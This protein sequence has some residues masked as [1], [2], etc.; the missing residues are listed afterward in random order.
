LNALEYYRNKGVE[1]Y[2]ESF[3]LGDDKDVRFVSVSF[4]LSLN[5]DV[6]IL[7]SLEWDSKLNIQEMIPDIRIYLKRQAVHPEAHSEQHDT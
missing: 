3:P 6:R 1:P 5:D 7:L 2:E 4:W